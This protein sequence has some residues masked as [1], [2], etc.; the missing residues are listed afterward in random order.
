MYRKIL[1][2][3]I[4]RAAVTD[5]NLEYEGSITIDKILMDRAGMMEYELVQVVNINN[6]AR[7]ETYIIE[8]QAGSGKIELN[9]AA[10]RL[11]HPGD[12]LIIMS[13][14]MVNDEDLADWKPTKV[15]VDDQNHIKDV[16]C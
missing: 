15:L 6:G 5:S 1:R 3:K 4:H 11:A 9:G 8:G 7:F 13:Y 16:L 10:A 14:V 2:S 12:R